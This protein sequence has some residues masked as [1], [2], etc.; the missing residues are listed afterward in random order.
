MY[1]GTPQKPHYLYTEK[2]ITRLVNR[3]KEKFIVLISVAVIALK[4][5]VIR[6]LFE[7]HRRTHTPYCFG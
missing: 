1:S 4:L 2:A 5:W 7:T 6:Y 3:G